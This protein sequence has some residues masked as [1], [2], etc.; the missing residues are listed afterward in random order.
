MMQKI[1]PFSP[2]VMDVLKFNLMFKKAYKT[3]RSKRH[4]FPTK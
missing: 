3:P 4:F 2:L 1:I